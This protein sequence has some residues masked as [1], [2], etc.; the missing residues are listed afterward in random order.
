MYQNGQ[1]D[2]KPDSDYLYHLK[3]YGHQ[4]NFGYKD[5]IPLWKAEKWNPEE[6]MK[7]YKRVGAKYF[8]SMLPLM[9]HRN[10]VLVVDKAFPL[11]GSNEIKLIDTGETLPHVL[12][13]TLKAINNEEHIRPI[14]YTDKELEYLDESYCDGIRTLRKE[15]YKTIQANTAGTKVQTLLHNDVFAKLDAASKLFSVLVLKTETTLPYTSIFIEFDCK[16]WS[17]AQENELRRRME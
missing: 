8:V 5:I 11:Q 1:K 12:D 15:L 17:E 10:W 3:H 4:S 2:G 6:L 9:G 13:V 7:L 14:I 16:Y